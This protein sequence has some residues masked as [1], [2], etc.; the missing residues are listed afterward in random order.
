MSVTGAP[1]SRNTEVV[2]VAFRVMLG[3]L[4]LSVWGS[5][6]HKGLYGADQYAALIRFYA[7]EG[8]AP[9]LWKDVMIWTADNAAVAA[10]LQLVAELVFGVCLLLGLLTRPVGLAAG[11]FLSALWV[12][13]IG[14]PN[15]WAWSLVFPALAA[16]AVAWLPEARAL[17]LD[18]LLLRRAPLDRLPRWATG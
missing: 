10:K 5:N 18:G 17:S 6:V 15:E 2:L 7:A 3:L 16:F 11:V 8:D 12:S 14:V 9:G 4:F 1:R 13:E